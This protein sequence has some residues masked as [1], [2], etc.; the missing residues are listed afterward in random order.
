MAIL[1]PDATLDEALDAAI[2]DVATRAI[3]CEGQPA[4]YAGV[5]AVTLA[6][7]T[8]DSSDFTKANGDTSGRKITL[9]QQS[10]NN[11]TADGDADHIAFTNGTDTLY[12][13]ITCTS[14]AVTSGNPVTI[15]AVDV[16]EIRDPA[17][18]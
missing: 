13:V 6:T 7:Y 9:A 12:A 10:G 2:G 14:Q 16:W 5:A 15:N 3:L 8:I 11:A 1:F 4:N 17:A 18:E